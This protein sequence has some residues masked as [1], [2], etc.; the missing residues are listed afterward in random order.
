M[1]KSVLDLL[2]FGSLIIIMNSSKRRA[3]GRVRGAAA[4]GL[5]SS[6][7]WL[8][9]KVRRWV[10]QP[11]SFGSFSINTWAV[12]E[13][14][15][16][17]D[18]E[19]EFN[20]QD[21]VLSSNSHYITRALRS[22]IAEKLEL[23]DSE[24]V[25]QYISGAEP[26]KHKA[27]AATINHINPTEAVNGSNNE[28]DNV[29]VAVPPTN[30]S[31]SAQELESEINTNN[32]IDDAQSLSDNNSESSSS[33]SSNSSSSSSDDEEELVTANAAQSKVEEEETESKAAAGNSVGE[34]SIAVPAF[35]SSPLLL[36]NS[37]A[38]PN[39]N[40]LH[41]ASSIRSSLPSPARFDQSTDIELSLDDHSSNSNNNPTEDVTMEDI[42]SMMG[43]FKHN[44]HPSSQTQ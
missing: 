35:E 5:L 37:S 29:N 23:N 27:K 22:T 36:N 44:N 2:L 40:N 7:R 8:K 42:D 15:D 34:D 16:N 25:L 11:K 17:M 10:I 26:K 31:S 20:D 33:S 38:T 3:S 32:V 43:E 21:N 1:Y 12:E 9:R 13:G 4:G 24:Q 28:L 14:Q 39:P 41:P 30:D 6:S 18:G 19:D